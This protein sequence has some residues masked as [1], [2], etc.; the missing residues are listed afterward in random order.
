SWDDRVALCRAVASLLEGVEVTEVEA[1]VPGEGRTIDTVEHLLR[2]RP[3]VSFRLVVGTDILH[4][5]DQWKAFDRLVTL[6]PL[7][8]LGRSGY[9]RTPA[10]PP[11]SLWLGDVPLPR[12]S[13]TEV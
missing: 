7:V 13:S 3:G 6:A 2:T 11:G 8:V 4:E 1:E 12:V 5:T 10:L 9:E